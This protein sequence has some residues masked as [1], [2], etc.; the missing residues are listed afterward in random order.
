MAVAN[1]KL[2]IG[3][4]KDI[5]NEAIYTWNADRLGT[6][7]N[8]AVYKRTMK[9]LA[10]GRTDNIAAL[11]YLDLRQIAPPAIMMTMGMWP[12]GVVDAVAAPDA[13]EFAEHLGGIAF[14]VRND[15]YGITFDSF[16]PVGFVIPGLV[17]ALSFGQ[18]T[19]AAAPMPAFSTD[20]NPANDINTQ[21]WYLVRFAGQEADG[22]AQGL[23]LSVSAV[24]MEPENHWYLN[25]LGVALYRNGQYEK[26]LQVL[27]RCQ[28]MNAVSDNRY[29]DASD[30]LFLAMTHYRLGHLDR[31]QE[32]LKAADGMVGPGS[33]QEINNFYS[34]AKA[35]IGK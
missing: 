15:E 9:G 31:A 24:E 26:A 3:S 23:D 18:Q 11:A 6:M 5:V 10:N 22:Y 8:S 17:A 32:M 27:Q 1:G 12:E 21:A 20:A 25:T 4:R 7:A 19:Y 35:M 30:T 14:A 28:E 33:D 2:I 16:S 13:G 34:E 29:D